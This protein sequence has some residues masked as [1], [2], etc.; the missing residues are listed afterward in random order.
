[1]RTRAC[2][3]SQSAT[4]P[5]WGTASPP[6]RTISSTTARAGSSS[7]P[8]P[9]IATPRSFTTTRAPCSARESACSRPS[10]WAAPVTMATFP[11]S[12]PMRSSPPKKA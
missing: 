9:S 2:A 7:R 6:A 10:P 11:S 8:L 3:A 12:S 4:S 1:V 5:K